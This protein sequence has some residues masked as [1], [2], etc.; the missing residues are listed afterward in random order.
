MGIRTI[1]PKNTQRNISPAYINLLDNDQNWN[2]LL[3]F[4]SIKDPTENM[5][6]NVAEAINRP[7]ILYKRLLT[8]NCVQR[9]KDMHIP[10]NTPRTTIN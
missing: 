5:V 6:P 10:R 2:F 3:I 8:I 7:V 9:I 1:P 4:M